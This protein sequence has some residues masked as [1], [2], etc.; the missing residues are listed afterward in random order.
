MTT[1][2]TVLALS[3]GVTLDLDNTVVF[4]MAI[5]ILLMFLLQPLLFD[6]VMRIFALREQRTEGEKMEAR[7]LDE[8]AGELLRRYEGEIERVNRVAAAERERI[9]GETTALEAEILKDAREAATRILDE[10]RGALE[11]EVARI[12]FELGRESEQIS[13]KIV[14]QALGRE[15]S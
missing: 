11:A 7:E 13:R 14:D 6:P 8:R 10:G 12:Q 15:A 2:S 1:L 4:Q 3:G 5:F 9:R